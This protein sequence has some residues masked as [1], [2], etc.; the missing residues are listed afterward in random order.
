MISLLGLALIHLAGAA[1][2][3]ALTSRAF[4]QVVRSPASGWYAVVLLYGL[5]LGAP[6]LVCIAA[7]LAWLRFSRPRPA[8]SAPVLP[9]SFWLTLGTLAALMLARP[10][11]PTQWDEFVWLAKARIESTGFATAATASLDPAQ[12]LVPS[13]YPPL[14][15]SLVA[16]L[17]LGVDSVSAHVGAASLLLVLC[18]ATALET[19]WSRLRSGHPLLLIAVLAT[20][21]VW[22]HARSTYL[23]LPV[24]LL[25][26]ALLGLALAE[27][28]VTATVLAVV[29]CALKD[30]GMVHVFAATAAIWVTAPVRSFKLLSLLL[31]GGLTAVLWRALLHVHGIANVDH[32]PTTPLWHWLPQALTLTAFHASDL[33]SW[34]V[35]WSIALALS[36][37]PTEDRTLRALRWALAVNLVLST[38]ALLAGPEQ[39]RVFAQNGTLLNRLLMQWWPVAAV[40]VLESRRQAPK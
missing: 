12:D 38:G 37:L 40:L 20:P 34:G 1:L 21:F 2:R 31:V 27:D 29:L 24:G 7:L 25:A 6:G 3:A 17:S 16:W 30:E 28:L 39:V 11:V 9:L 8:P 33:W 32:A 13:G 4:T 10:W 5:S 15:P 14:W 23:D 36:L 35:F 26:V 18:V 19:W 22:V